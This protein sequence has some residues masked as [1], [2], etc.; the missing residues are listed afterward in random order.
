[1]FIKI[2]LFATGIIAIVIGVWASNDTEKVYPAIIGVVAAITLVIVGVSITIVPT[3]YVGV[4]TINGQI[5]DKPVK[6]GF[7]W[8]TPLIGSIHLI[9]CKQQEKDFGSLKIWAETSERTEVY[10][11]NV[12][13]DYQI[14]GE[15][16]A[17][18]WANVEEW[19]TNLLKQTSVESGIKSAAKGFS[20]I[21]VTDRSKIESSAKESIQKALNEKYKNQIVTVVSVNIGNIN[22]SDAYNDAIEKKAQ[23]KLAAETAEYESKRKTVEAEA[24]AEQKRIVAQGKA[25]AM[26][27]EA[28]AEAEA[29]REISDSLTD[30]I[31]E[32]R[33][34]EK[35]DGVMP[36]VTGSS[37]II[38]MDSEE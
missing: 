22:F 9:N 8:N 13:V 3:G 20:D 31:I 5:S 34:I 17:W 36:K 1:M 35:W 38:Q 4:R 27:I 32:L 18:I 24:E 6:Q 10:F 12:V 37:A 23:A 28:E 16:A 11:E 26:L 19:D 14:E 33:K 29:N 15:Y 21:D 25:D 2:A 30:K 7:N